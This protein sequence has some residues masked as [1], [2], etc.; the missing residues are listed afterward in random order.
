MP[1]PN[2][3]PVLTGERVELRPIVADDWQGMFAAAADPLIWEVHP[4]RDRYK[5]PVFREYF[6]SGL[7][8][9]MGLAIIDKQTSKIIGSSRYHDYDPKLSEVEI[10][11]TF[12]A[13][14]YWGGMYNREIKRLMLDHAFQFVGTVI[15]LVGEKNFRSQRAMEKIGGVR[16][17]QLRERAYHGQTVPH[18]V[19]EIRK[20]AEDAPT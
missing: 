11:W 18:V 2:F 3:Q 8:S 13:R 7:G 17:P 12:L 9:R 16:R 6:E 20:P 14:P 5:E 1:D 15:F 4:V 10:G 19:Y